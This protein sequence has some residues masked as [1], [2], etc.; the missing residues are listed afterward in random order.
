MLVNEEGKNFDAKTWF[1]GLLTGIG[2]AAPITAYFV[3]KVYDKKS[4][5]ESSGTPKMGLLEP[6]RGISEGHIPTAEEINNYD[7]SIPDEEA[8][9]ASQIPVEDQERFRDMLERYNGELAD[10]AFVISQETFMNDQ[11]NEKAY[12]NWYEGDNKF[13]EDL[14][15]TQDPLASFGVAN[16]ND[17]F[18]EANAKLSGDPDIVYVRNN[19]QTTDYEITRIHDSYKNV[20]EGT[21][22]IG[23]ANPDM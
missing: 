4:P 12:V 20:V 7:L 14:I 18:N 22:G 9:E 16:G 17:I 5:V 21:S 3:K 15:P 2:V 13:E 11:T 10:T 23:Q 1:F 8:T 6:P 19:K